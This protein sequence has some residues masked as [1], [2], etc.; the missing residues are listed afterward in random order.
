MA[1]VKFPSEM[2][3]ASNIAGGDKLMISKEGN[4]EAYQATFNQAKDYLN[5]TGIELEPLVGGDTSET[6]LVVPAGPVG[7][8]RTAEVASGKWYNFGSGAVEAT[9][10]RRWKAYWTGT[11][12]SLKDMGP[13]PAPDTSDLATKEEVA[14]KVSQDAIGVINFSNGQNIAPFLA[15]SQITNNDLFEDGFLQDN[16]IHLRLP[17]IGELQRISIRLHPVGFFQIY[18]FRERL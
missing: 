2:P 15:W 10:D 16:G 1:T 5:I 13:L 4:G 18:V 14:E 3:S 17:Q 11:A 7:E 9:A 8:A 12:W 6:A